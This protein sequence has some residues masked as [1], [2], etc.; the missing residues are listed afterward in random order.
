MRLQPV[1]AIEPHCS[2]SKTLLVALTNTGAL[3]GW[4]PTS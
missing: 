4:I 3:M 2:A 1:V